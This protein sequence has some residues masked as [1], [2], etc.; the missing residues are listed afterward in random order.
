MNNLRPD[1][2][3]RLRTAFPVEIAVLA[4]VVLAACVFVVGRGLMV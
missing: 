4:V 1:T 3:R 2:V